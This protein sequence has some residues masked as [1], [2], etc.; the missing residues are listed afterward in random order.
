MTGAIYLKVDFKGRFTETLGN[1]DL[2]IIS[3]SGPFKWERG[4]GGFQMYAF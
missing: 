1:F 2:V 3:E 4:G